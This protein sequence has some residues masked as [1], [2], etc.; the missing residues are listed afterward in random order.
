V[1]ADLFER[2]LNYLA[3][4]R[5]LSPRTVEAYRRDLQQFRQ[6]A[7]REELD[8]TGPAAV[9]AFLGELAR[10]GLAA[11]TI[12]RVLSTLRGYFRFLR[13]HGNLDRSPADGVRNRKMRRRLPGFLFAEQMDRF[14]PSSV[15]A[16]SAGGF[17]A[18]RDRALLEFLYSTGC[19]AAEAVGASLV[20]VD[21]KNGSVR[22]L[23]KGGKERLVFLG[24]V[25]VEALRD[26]LLLR[27]RR[28][29]RGDQS[30]LFVN[31]RGGRLTTRG[32][33]FI[34]KRYVE[35]SGWQ[36][37]VTPHTLRHSFATHVLD[38]GAD[39]RVVQELLGHASLS[40]TQIYTHVGL[41]K[42][43]QVYQKAH[44]HAGGRRT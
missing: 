41:E 6:F 19:R 13:R 22:V 3:G 31:M 37:P 12:N 39:I 1:A 20:D 27:K 7:E 18:V 36:G 10:R 33:R 24:Q 32:L 43:R 26:Y 28:V 16:A 4:V 34:L 11:S 44:P 40:T 21:L 30:A 9:R 42:L 25:A 17:R 15:A 14:L 35:E 2:Y 23:G 5:S 38:E 29:P 8:A